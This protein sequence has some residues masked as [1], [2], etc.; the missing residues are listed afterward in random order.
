M[1]KALIRLGTYTD[2]VDRFSADAALSQLQIVARSG[3]LY[4][5][6]GWSVADS[7]ALAAS[8]DLRTGVEVNGCRSGWRRY[9]GPHRRGNRGRRRVV[10]ATGGPAALARLLPADPDWGELGPPVTAACLDLGVSRVRR[11]RATS[12]RSTIRST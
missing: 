5:H 4:L 8:L 9:R 3:V 7:S 10:V 12:S 2:D 11:I 6:G 1:L